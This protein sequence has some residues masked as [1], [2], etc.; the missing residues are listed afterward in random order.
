M[1]QSCSSIQLF[2][3]SDPFCGS[4][5]EIILLSVLLLLILIKL[6]SRNKGKC[7]RF[8]LMKKLFPFV[9]ENQFAEITS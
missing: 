3:F 9:L 6:S 7:I 5:T 4:L 2:A 8:L 1:H